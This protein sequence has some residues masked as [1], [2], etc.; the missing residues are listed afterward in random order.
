MVRLSGIVLGIVVLSGCSA[1]TSIER[2][3]AS[4]KIDQLYQQFSEA[5]DNLD[6]DKVANLYAEDAFYLI[7]NAQRAIIEGRPSIQKSFTGF[8]EGAAHRNRQIDISFRIVNRKIAD[9]LAF[10][11][12]YYRTRSKPD[13]AADFPEGGGVGKFVTVMGLMPNGSWKFLLDGYNSAPPEAFAK[14]DSAHNPVGSQ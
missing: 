6:T 3:Q 7:P 12:G 1:Q 9:S 11:V 5:Y 13:T 4:A 2:D 10:D 14:A 8:M